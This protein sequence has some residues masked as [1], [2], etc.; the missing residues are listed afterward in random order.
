[1]SEIFTRKEQATMTDIIITNQNTVNGRNYFT[2]IVGKKEIEI[3]HNQ[4]QQNLSVLVKNASHRVYRGM[5][6]QFWGQDVFSQAAEAYKSSEVK[7]AVKFV[8][9]ETNR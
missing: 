5:G 6:R 1:M 7:A 3:S 2:L 4:S 9:K 8:Q